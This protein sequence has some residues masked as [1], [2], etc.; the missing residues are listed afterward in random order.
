MKPFLKRM[1]P[2]AALLL[3]SFLLVGL[4]V[5]FRM[6]GKAFELER[7]GFATSTSFI[8]TDDE[9]SLADLG[10]FASALL[11]VDRGVWL[12]EANRYGSA[13]LPF[14][15]GPGLSGSCPEALVGSSRLSEVQDGCFVW[16]GTPYKVVGIL[17]QRDESL[18]SDAALLSANDLLKGY[19]ASALRFDGLGT[20]AL[21][22][23]G[24]P[25][26]KAQSLSSALSSRL[27]DAAVI[28][29]FTLASLL[30]GWC[31]ALLA[32]LRYARGARD[33]YRVRCLLGTQRIVLLRG[34][35]ELGALAVGASIAAAACLGNVDLAVF[36][37][38][39]FL[40]VMAPPLVTGAVAALCLRGGQHA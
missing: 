38:P 15:N 7:D 36:W 24:F 5:T 22:R 6:K 31:G 26:A 29:L 34:A 14:H 32:T 4:A 11:E 10:P 20:K 19:P 28:S 35:I 3:A 17:G 2:T 27:G 9:V 8:V 40:L 30:V 25:D 13:A 18:L 39:W 33:E 21:L 1:M 16:N 23:L 37:S 12:F